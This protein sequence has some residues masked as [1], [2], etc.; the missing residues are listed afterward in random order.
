MLVC[1]WSPKGGSGT[2]VIAASAALVLARRGPVRLADLTGDLPAVLGMSGD[3]DTGLREWL[4]VGPQAPTDALAHL[5]HR[6]DDRVALLPAGVT[7]LAPAAPEAG[8]ALAVALRDDARTTIVDAGR[9][10]HPALYALAEIADANVPV[11]RACYLAL[12][13]AVRH[14]ALELARGAVLIEEHGRALGV[15]DVEDVLGVPVLARIEA[16]TSIAHAVDAGVLAARMPD[17]LL[18]PL[19]QMLSQLGCADD[20]RAA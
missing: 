8:A 11:V 13:R 17:S 10:D 20:E 2:S 12:R 16:R 9:I 19:R 6:V 3:P 14:P 1:F 15:R 7:T 5:E 18:R 4:R